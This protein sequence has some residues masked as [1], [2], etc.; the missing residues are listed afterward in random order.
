MGGEA[1]KNN[2]GEPLTT[3]IFK[4]E[5]T[6]TL[7]SLLL[8]VLK[9]AGIDTYIPIGSTG[10]K[11]ES[12]DID[13]AV[14]PFPLD[15]PATVKGIKAS[16]LKSF[17]SSVGPDRAKLLGSNLAIMFPISGR[18]NEF[19]QI[20][21]M[22]SSNPEQTAWLMA[23]TETG[24]KGVYRNLLLSYLAKVKSSEEPGL[25]ITIM[26]PGGIQVVQN[27]ETVVPRNDNPDTIVRVLG[28]NA[29]KN[30]I[31]TFED[32]VKVIVS[33][34]HYSKSI[35][36]FEGYIG[37]YLNDAKTAIE[38][39]KAIE[40]LKKFNGLVESIRKMLKRI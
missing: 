7:D 3:T 34:P 20:D 24:I 12:G 19:V 1:F 27:G 9:P 13:I 15:N 21:L 37:S 25:K 33:D 22:L 10:K 8:T 17:Q 35:Q 4:N 29:N 38:A 40:F 16:L 23:G 11:Q 14:G 28:L 5:V 39:S 18:P 2:T 32:L 30:D 6:P 26:F 31:Q 36:G